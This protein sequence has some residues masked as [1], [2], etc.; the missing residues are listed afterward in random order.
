MEV[1]R[2][3]IGYKVE[4]KYD[5]AHPHEHTARDRCKAAAWLAG[6]RNKKL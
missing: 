6:H 1:V 3:L 4:S 2:N 5:D